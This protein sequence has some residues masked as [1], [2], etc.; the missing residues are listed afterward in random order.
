MA[1]PVTFHPTFAQSLL[2]GACAGTAVDL[3]F[4]PLDT[5]KTRLQ[6]SKGFAASGGFKGVYRG[7][8]SVIV[9]SAPGA[10]AFF[11]TYDTLK[12]SL[13]DPVAHPSPWNHVISASLGEVVACSV[14]VPVEVVKSRTQTAS[15]GLQASSKDAFKR[16][17][18]T[19]GV[20]GLYRGFGM[21]IAREIPFTSIQ[22]SLY[23]F[24]KAR[25]SIYL[26]RRPLKAYEAA[27]C[28]SISGGVA[29]A[30]TTPLDVLKTRVMLDLRDPSQPSPSLIARLAQIY[31]VEGPGALFSGVV[32]RTLWIS[33]GGA[34]FLGV[35]EWAIS[36]QTQ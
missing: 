22:F 33:A 13:P 1:D 5:L 6:S 15:Y 21:T 16:V 28:G 27:V 2:A 3:L 34:V 23:E 35:Y 26:G 18:A 17:L 12:Q 8:G 20:L 10:A 25:A 14:R 4:Y 31:K 24:L 11:V 32:P 36:V 30:A 29:A 7:V 19:D 9:G